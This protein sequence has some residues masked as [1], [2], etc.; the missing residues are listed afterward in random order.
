LSANS[1]AAIVI[2]VSFFSLLLGFGFFL[3]CRKSSYTD[4]PVARIYRDIESKLSVHKNRGKQQQLEEQRLRQLEANS[5]DQEPLVTHVP[6]TEPG[7]SI[8]PRLVT[9]LAMARPPMTTSQNDGRMTPSSTFTSLFRDDVLG[10]SGVRSGSSLFYQEN[11]SDPDESGCVTRPPGPFHSVPHSSTAHHDAPLLPPSIDPNGD[12]PMSQVTSS[13]NRSAVPNIAY[14]DSPVSDADETAALMTAT[15]VHMDSTDGS[16]QPRGASI[17]FARLGRLSWFDRIPPDDDPRRQS[18][19]PGARMSVGNQSSHSSGERH[20]I[21]ERSQASLGVSQG[22]RLSAHAGSISSGPTIYYDASSRPRSQISAGGH[23]PDQWGYNTPD[24][25]DMPAPPSAAGTF[26]SSGSRPAHLRQPPGLLQGEHENLGDSPPPAE[27]RWRSFRSVGS[28]PEFSRTSSIPEASGSR[29]VTE[30]SSQGSRTGTSIAET[31]PHVTKEE[32]T[33]R[34]RANT[35]TSFGTSETIITDANTGAVMHF[36]SK[37]WRSSQGEGQWPDD[38][39]TEFP[40][41]GQAKWYGPPNSL[42]RYRAQT[43]DPGTL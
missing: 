3:C 12:R 10:V 11:A 8:P 4:S 22:H 6:A 40:P 19:V 34:S 36:P 39:W 31:T 28:N 21:S 26:S 33:N 20:L 15:R 1:I 2:V 17:G 23:A 29:L 32:W 37:V 14:P 24:I 41:P 42:E 18:Y 27:E 38:A 13:S 25:L 7:V 30:V 35:S 16:S 5:R 43:G 9:P